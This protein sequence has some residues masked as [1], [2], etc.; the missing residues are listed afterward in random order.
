[1]DIEQKIQKA[2]QQ[3]QETMGQINELTA[4]QLRLQGY[5]Q[6]LQESKAEQ[7]K[8]EEKSNESK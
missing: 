1:M 3:I 5:L 2:E 4:F 6:A 8:E 7:V